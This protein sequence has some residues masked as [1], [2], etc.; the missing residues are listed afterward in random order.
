MASAIEQCFHQAGLSGGTVHALYVVDVRAYGILPRETADRVREL[1]YEEG[2]RAVGYLESRAE[3]R[4]VDVVTEVREGI[5]HETILSYV[6][7]NDVDLVVMGTHGHTGDGARLVGSV[8]ES[9][10]RHAD[11]PVMTVRMQEADAVAIEEDV[12]DSQRRYI[13]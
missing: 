9:V 3:E 4:G 8:A 12:P 6:D 2:E 10:V 1:L 13:A 5:P 7:E 11:V